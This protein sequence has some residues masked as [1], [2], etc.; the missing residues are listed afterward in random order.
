[1]PQVREPTGSV[2]E[3]NHKKHPMGAFLFPIL[4]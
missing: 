2:M 1:M 4:R 3:D